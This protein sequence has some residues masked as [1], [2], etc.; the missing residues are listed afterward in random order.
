[1]GQASFTP[2]KSCR[3]SGPRVIAR[4]GD[5]GDAESGLLLG[6]AAKHRACF[7]AEIPIFLFYILWFPDIRAGF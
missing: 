1:M 2:N 3:S 5:M 6:L 4:D 7:S